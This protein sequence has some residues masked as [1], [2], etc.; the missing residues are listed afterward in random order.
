MGR[1]RTSERCCVPVVALNDLTSLSCCRVIPKLRST[2]VLVEP[3]CSIHSSSARPVPPTSGPTFPKSTRHNTRHSWRP[4]EPQVPYLDTSPPHDFFP[5]CNPP[6]IHLL[7]LERVAALGLRPTGAMPL[8]SM[9][10]FAPP[11]SFAGCGSPPNSPKPWL[12]A[13]LFCRWRPCMAVC[14]KLAGPTL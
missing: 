9:M 14:R 2:T 7:S 5:K 1:Q 6:A 4:H 8:K 10:D 11:G 3:M 12:R 13:G